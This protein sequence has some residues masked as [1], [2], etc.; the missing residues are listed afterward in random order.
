MKI[1]I[2]FLEKKFLKKINQISRNHLDPPLFE[3][4]QNLHSF[5]A[6]QRQNILNFLDMNFG[7]FRGKHD[8]DSYFF[9][10]I[11]DEASDEI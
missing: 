7:L 11:L 3:S 8:Q 10:Y 6:F 5:T 4:S 9:L 2:F 1:I